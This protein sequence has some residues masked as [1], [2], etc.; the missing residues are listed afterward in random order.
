MAR[1]AFLPLFFGDFL[2]STVEWA[3]EEA[4]LYLT[5]LGYQWS[6]GSLPV[7]DAKLCRLVRWDR[8]TFDRYWPQVAEKFVEIDGRRFNLRLEEHRAKTQK[9]AEKNRAAGKAGAEARWG[10]DGERHDDANG[11]TDGER[12]ES[13][14]AATNGNPSHPIPST[15]LRSVDPPKPPLHPNGRWGDAPEGCDPQAW[16][17]WA[18][19]KRGQPAAQTLT[20]HANFMRSLATPEAQR[21]AVDHSIRN[22]YS[23]CFSPKDGNRGTHRKTFE[24]L[25]SDLARKAGIA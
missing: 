2:A 21:E 8:K 11:A 19:Y 24:Q 12:H 10:K 23:G 6:L 5:C 14:I 20:K 13:G 15:S 1:E 17:E 9:V 7:D 16:A 22:G 4:S 3:G 25:Q 18:R